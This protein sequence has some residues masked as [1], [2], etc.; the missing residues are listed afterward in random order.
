MTCRHKIT[1]RE[2]VKDFMNRCEYCGKRHNEEQKYTEM[3]AKP[4]AKFLIITFVITGLAW[5][6]LAVLTSLNIISFSY[7]LGTILHIIGGFGPTIATLFVLEEKLTVKSILRFVFGYRKKS[8]I[9]FF[10]LCILE[11]LVIG[12]SS[13]QF[14]S[15][16]S[17]YLM[18]L[19]LLQATFIYGGEEE[20][21]WRGVMQ[22][23][24]EKKL[25]FPVATIITGLVWGI[26]HIPL[27]F[28]NGSS[29]QNMSF[30]FFL[31]LAVILSFWLAVIYKKTK[32]VFACSVFH[33]LTN[34]LLSVFVIKVNLLLIIGLIA[35][36]VYSI[37][38]WYGEEAKQ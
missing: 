7:P 2:V 3:D 21:G 22:P 25:N 37:Y 15:A 29:Q 14:N 31:A 5:C 1:N 4:L 27:W 32:C 26:W 33:G 24:L 6:G 36:L 19:I 12:L 34:T 38:S 17:W 23:L 20:L 11:M 30:L 18:P 13:R 10:I 9:Y 16:L 8:L 28:V 35:M